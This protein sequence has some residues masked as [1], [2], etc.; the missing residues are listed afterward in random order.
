MNPESPIRLR[1]L[2]DALPKLSHT[3]ANKRRLITLEKAVTEKLDEDPIRP[4]SHTYSGAAPEIEPLHI[5]WRFECDV[6]SLHTRLWDEACASPPV[7]KQGSSKYDR[8]FDRVPHCKV[9]TG[10]MGFPLMQ[11]PATLINGIDA[12]NLRHVWRRRQ[13]HVR[14]AA[15]LSEDFYFGVNAAELALG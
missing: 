2:E 12:R 13:C 14:I 15:G 8:K 5:E 1:D 9:A 3:F 11:R 10:A 6:A 4:S 7:Q